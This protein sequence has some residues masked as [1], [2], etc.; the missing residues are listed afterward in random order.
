MSESHRS[1][2]AEATT[3]DEAALDALLECHLPELLAFV[4]LRAGNRLL[5][6]ESS[7]D[8][9]QS[10]CREVLQDLPHMRYRDEAH[11]R[12]WLFTAAERKILDRA[13]YH[14]R[15]Q[16]DPERLE[17]GG[18]P[19]SD[20][21][22]QALSRAYASLVTP[23]Q[24]AMAREELGAFERGFQSLPDDY[25]EVILAA[26]LL[27]LSH[28]EI[29]HRMGRTPAAVRVLLHRALARLA[30]LSSAEQSG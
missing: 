10:T 15:A 20:D 14:G 19:A 23:S 18:W 16:R 11:F 24:Q 21:E 8:L 5:R 9:V 28:D 13:R 22:S 12:N 3:G 27:G 4:R 6:L 1:L 7:M 26:R 17:S 25:R 2:V 29:A 30:R